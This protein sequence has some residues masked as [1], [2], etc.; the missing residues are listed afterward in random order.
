MLMR[1]LAVA[2]A[3]IVAVPAGAQRRRAVAPSPNVPTPYRDLY[4]GLS[5]GLD[6]WMAY[7]NTRTPVRN[8]DITFAAEV[9]TANTNR[10]SAL[11]RS[12]ALP[13]VRLFLDRLKAMGV[14][15]ASISI[16][17][18]MLDPSFP[19]SSEYL[20]F[21]REVAR[22]V[23]QRN[24]KLHVETGV[25]FTGT[26]FSDLDVD[27]SRLTLGQY[28]E[29]KRVMAERVLDAMRPD[30]LGLGG[31]PDTEAALTGLRE[32]NDPDNYANALQVVIA[33][34]DKKGAVVGAGVGT[35]SPLSFAQK[36]VRVEGLDAITLHIYPIWRAPIENATL[37]SALARQNGKRLTL[38]EAWL[39][40]ALP[41]EATN[42]AANEA[43]FKRDAFDFWSPLD[44]KFLTTMVKLAEVEGIDVVSPFWSTFFFGSLTWTPALEAASYA[45]VVQRVNE[46]AVANLVAGRRTPL[47]EH[48]RR[49]IR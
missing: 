13:G 4:A 26:A 46:A 38:D 6:Q 32:L 20:S 15:A 33:G 14:E 47:G 12:D 22:E 17:Y 41:S 44:E 27:F 7:L 10:G 5:S 49:L 43:I 39:Y 21:Y 1:V 8:H 40:K 42:I 29:G 18:P 35:W 9:I 30:F 16:G 25:V 3:V 11:L 28:I 48:Y 36:L 23:R 24:M 31:E 2:L 19:R 45:T 34:L 37:I